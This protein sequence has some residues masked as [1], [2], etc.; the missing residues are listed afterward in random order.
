M[1]VDVHCH[2]WPDQIAQRALSGRA[3]QL[4]RRGDGTLGGLRAAMASSAV[5]RAV[6][7]GIAD[8]ARHVDG[9]NRFVARCKADG[10]LG[11]GTVHAD[12]SVEENLASLRRNGI[13][14]V[15]VNTLFQPF[16]INHP[17]MYELYEAFGSEIAVIVHI[18]AGGDKAANERA[19]PAMARHIIQTFPDLRLVCCHFG[20]YQQLDDAEAEVL[21]L[22]VYLETS[23]P[24]TLAEIAPARVREIVGK[25][26]SDRIVF[27]S[28][29]PLADP[30]AEIAAIQALGLSDDTVENILGRNFL[31]LLGADADEQ[32][33]QPGTGNDP[34]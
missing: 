33:T 6:V 27:G 3:S 21:G 10:F 13:R 23:W 12:L 5:D 22:N 34:S 16:P 28:D 29:W 9:V 7:L 15:K 25:H 26:G 11:F 4:P 20:G 24:P 17:R 18:G 14:G 1:V 2:A 31:R 8:E 32:A 19:T 30:V